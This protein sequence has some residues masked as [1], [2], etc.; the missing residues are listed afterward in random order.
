[1]ICL[2]GVLSFVH[3]LL[4]SWLVFMST[5]IKII[6]LASI[7]S[8]IRWFP[9]S[10][11]FN[12]VCVCVGGVSLYTCDKTHKL[13]TEDVLQE[14]GLSTLC[15]PGIELNL[16]GFAAIA[17]THWAISSVCLPGLQWAS[18]LAMKFISKL[19]PG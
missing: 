2:G 3:N 4:L 19:S 8:C 12:Y 1:M 13:K 6:S 10:L 9:K 5:L 18:T 15:F 16:S 17:L 14:S 11:F 7:G